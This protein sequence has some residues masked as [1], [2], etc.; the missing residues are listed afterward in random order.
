MR[1]S[2]KDFI[3]GVNIAYC[4]H[5]A[6]SCQ[7]QQGHQEVWTA[8]FKSQAFVGCYIFQPYSQAEK[9]HGH[10]KRRAILLE[11]VYRFKRSW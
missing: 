10:K 6:V 2:G 3:T 4:P 5:T 7:Y 11:Y 8:W 9:N 1:R